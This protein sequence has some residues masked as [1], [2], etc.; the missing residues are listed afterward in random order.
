[1][2]SSCAIGAGEKNWALLGHGIV[3]KHQN[4]GT[5]L[6]EELVVGTQRAVARLFRVRVHERKSRG[7][8]DD[9]SLRFARPLS[10]GG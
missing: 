5:E 4:L 6:T 8:A 1:M 9:F 10:V 2:R 3:G 7:V